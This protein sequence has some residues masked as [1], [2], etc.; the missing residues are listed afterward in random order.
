MNL[1]LIAL[2]PMG[3]IQALLVIATTVAVL[4]VFAVFKTRET[5]G[6]DLGM[7]VNE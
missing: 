1:S 6:C 2:K 3:I 5:F 4:G 7:K